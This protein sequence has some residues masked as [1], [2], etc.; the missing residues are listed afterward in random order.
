MP[1]VFSVFSRIEAVASISIMCKILR[2]LFERGL[3]SLFQSLQ[4][5]FVNPQHCIRICL[6]LRKIPEIDMYIHIS[7]LSGVV[8]MA[9][10]GKRK[11]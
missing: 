1:T 11:C 5:A 10:T 7:K 9:E 4:G 6:K 2:I 8:T 3:Y